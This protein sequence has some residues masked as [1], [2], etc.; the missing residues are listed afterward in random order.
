MPKHYNCSKCNRR[1]K[2]DHRRKVG[3]GF[4][5]DK[6]HWLGKKNHKPA[7]ARIDMKTE[8]IDLL[9]LCC[10]K[11]N[12]I[13][14]ICNEKVFP[15]KLAPI[16]AIIDIFVKQCVFVPSGVRICCN[17]LSGQ[18]IKPSVVVDASKIK[19]VSSS[20]HTTEI[21]ELLNNLRIRILDSKSRKID[22]D[23]PNGLSED[24]YYRL[25]GLSTQQ[26]DD[27]ITKVIPLKS[28]ELR[29]KRF[30]SGLLL[31]KLR[32]G[33]LPQTLSNIMWYEK[34]FTGQRISRI[35]VTKTSTWMPMDASEV[36]SSFPHLSEEYLRTLAFGVYQL[37]QA[38]SYTNEHLND[39]CQYIV[40]VSEHSNDLLHAKIQFRQ[41]SSKNTT[42]GLNTKQLMIPFPCVNAAPEL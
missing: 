30:A 39:D 41:T 19:K 14:F 10:G 3:V 5:C 21:T 22:F 28:T 37:K 4:I 12:A 6:C 23:D 13:C 36:L 17:H 29:S 1:T 25:T 18:N 32:T 26:F 31:T 24:D 27:L 8:C 33:L 2:T 35:R 9:I 34:C 38:I 11:S 7:V 16:Q 40:N 15:M 42:A 20:L